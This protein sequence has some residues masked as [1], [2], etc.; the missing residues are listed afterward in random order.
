MSIV[1]LDNAATTPICDAAKKVIIDNLDEYYNPASV[2]EPSRK[3]RVKVEEAR[4]TIAELIGAKSADEIY[5]TS[6]GSEANTWALHDRLSIA[7]N[8]EHSSIYPDLRYAVGQDGLVNPEKLNHTLH[9]LADV[10]EKYECPNI[11]SVQHVNN[12]IGVIQPIKDCVTVAHNNGCVFHTDAVQSL[13]HMKINVQDLGVDMLSASGHKFGAPKGVGFLYVKNGVEI[14]PLIYGGS[15]E[16]GV[17]G[18][19]TNILGV[20]AMAQALQDTQNNLLEIGGKISY[21]SAI[22]RENLLNITGIK[23][24]VLC[25]DAPCFTGILSMQVENCKGADIVAMAS[26]FNLLISS[27]SACHEGLAKNSHVLRAIGLSDTQGLSS[28]RL[29]VGRYNTEHDIYFASDILAKIVKSLRMM[30][31]NKW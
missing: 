28:I 22:L 21:L 2:Y 24:N 7:T 9:N 5:F 27:G 3:M 30:G 4:E 15:Q 13:P 18:G 10:Y 20:L 6:G 1:Y 16:R 8:I 14:N 31:V 17:R 29:S 26:E 19:T 12:E 25:P 23:A 11:V